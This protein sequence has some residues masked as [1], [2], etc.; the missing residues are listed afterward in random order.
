MLIQLSSDDAIDNYGE[1]NNYG[2][3]DDVAFSTVDNFSTGQLN[4]YCTLD[5]FGTRFLNQGYVL[6][7]AGAVFSYGNGQ[8]FTN[9][10]GTLDNMGSFSAAFKGSGFNN[11]NG[12]VINNEAGASMS[13]GGYGTGAA[14]ILSMTQ[15]LA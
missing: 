13:N 1:F 10:G 7:A 5:V 2:E 11:I 15:I 9:D 12:A 3:I 6:N 8:T 4:N 14:L